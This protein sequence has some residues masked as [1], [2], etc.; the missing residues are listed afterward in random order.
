M[1]FS[2]AEVPPDREPVEDETALKETEETPEA[3]PEAV[4]EET[5]RESVPE[6]TRSDLY[7]EAIVGKFK[8]KIG[9]PLQLL[10]MAA[11]STRENR[12]KLAGSLA[13][14]TLDKYPQLTGETAVDPVALWSEIRSL[15]LNAFEREI[16]QAETV[17][18]ATA[19]Q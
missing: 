13:A 9:I 6:E 3:P 16:A 17:E 19:G 12:A 5:Q 11:S 1:S 7:E 18:V 10:K 4:H 14:Q 2:P 15:I 8:I